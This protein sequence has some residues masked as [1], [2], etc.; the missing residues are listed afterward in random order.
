LSLAESYGGSVVCT[1][2]SLSL[3]SILQSS[4]GQEEKQLRGRKRS[5]AS[6]CSS[7]GSVTPTSKR[8]RTPVASG[9][10]STSNTRSGSVKGDTT[11][12]SLSPQPQQLIKLVKP[13]AASSGGKRQTPATLRRR[14]GLPANPSSQDLGCHEEIVIEE[15][16]EDDDE[17]EEEAECSATQCLQPVADQIIWVQ[18]D[19]C[20]E[21]FHCVCVGLTKEYAEQIDIYKCAVCKQVATTTVVPVTSAVGLALAS[22]PATKVGTLLSSFSS[23]SSSSV[24]PG[25]T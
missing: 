20:H 6:P 4:G 13:G 18:C 22:R 11:P 23:S 14:T 17:E 25:Q 7:D 19:H 21:W 24:S 9:G 15:E 10:S 5:V 8:R 16:D 2:L 3:S 12:V 1:S